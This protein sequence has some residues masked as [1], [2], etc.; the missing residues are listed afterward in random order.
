MHSLISETDDRHDKFNITLCIVKCEFCY[1]YSA[2]QLKDIK[3][4]SF[5][6]IPENIF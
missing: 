6:Y 4:L 5:S 3:I 2:N 1:L